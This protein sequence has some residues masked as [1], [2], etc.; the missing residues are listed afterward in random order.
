MTSTD[1]RITTEFIRLIQLTPMMLR[2]ATITMQM[3][4]PVQAGTA[5]NRLLK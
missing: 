4:V 3:R 5:V 1:A 2:T